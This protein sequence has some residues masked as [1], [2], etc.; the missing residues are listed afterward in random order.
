MKKTTLPHKWLMLGLLSVFVIIAGLSTWALT[1]AQDS[2][3]DVLS[4]FKDV[5]MEDEEFDAI[6]YL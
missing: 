4:S 2:T 1:S 5:S 3:D 6:T